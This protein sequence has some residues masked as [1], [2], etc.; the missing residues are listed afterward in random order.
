M[1]ITIL[2]RDLYEPSLSNYIMY[3]SAFTPLNYTVLHD[4][5]SDWVT[6]TEMGY[7]F[8]CLAWR[9]LLRQY[10]QGG[11]GKPSEQPESYFL[12]L[13]EQYAF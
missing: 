8:L 9:V 11:A 4:I 10:Q 12:G 3:T 7:R 5:W 6:D 13:V 2:I 1:I